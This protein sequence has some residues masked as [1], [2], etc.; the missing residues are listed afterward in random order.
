VALH[1]FDKGTTPRFLDRPEHDI[2]AWTRE[3]LARYCSEPGSRLELRAGRTGHHVVDA[4]EG[5]D[6][7]MIALTWSQD[8]SPGRA[9]V[10]REALARTCLPLLLVPVVGTTKMSSSTITTWRRTPVRI[11]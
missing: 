1:V 7:D 10:V 5:E 6:A 8:L 11:A 2:D 4:A 9:A 3:F